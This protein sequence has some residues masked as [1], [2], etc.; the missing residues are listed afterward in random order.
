MNFSGGMCAFEDE[1]FGMYTSG[2]TTYLYKQLT[3]KGT[4]NYADGH[5]PITANVM[6][7]WDSVGSPDLYKKY[8]WITVS[9]GECDSPT[10]GLTVKSYMN[11]SLAAYHSNF[12]MTF[13]SGGVPQEQKLKAGKANSMLFDLSNST[14]YQ[15]FSIHGWMYE[16]AGEFREQSSAW[17]NQNR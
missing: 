2:S 6:T 14:I 17:G 9:G 7:F 12:T 16:V 8:L 13:L 5:N 1:I 11:Y 15:T 10:W 3:T 4:H